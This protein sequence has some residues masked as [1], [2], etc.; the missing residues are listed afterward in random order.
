MYAAVDVLA[1]NFYRMRYTSWDPNDPASCDST[2]TRSPQKQAVTWVS[3]MLECVRIREQYN[4][5][6]EIIPFLWW[7]YGVKAGDCHMDVVNSLDVAESIRV[8]RRWGADGVY[9]WGYVNPSE[10]DYYTAEPLPREQVQQM[11]QERWEE[12]LWEIICQ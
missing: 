7:H 4:P 12:P 3:A 8:P 1:P 2:R 6:A 10:M 5:T 11:L 9:L